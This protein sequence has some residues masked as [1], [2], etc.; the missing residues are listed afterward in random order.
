VSNHCER[1]QRAFLRRLHSRRAWLRPIRATRASTTWEWRQDHVATRIIR[2]PLRTLRAWSDC[3]VATPGLLVNLDI[4]DRN[5]E[6]MEVI[7]RSRGR[8]LSARQDVP[9]DGRGFVADQAWGQRAV[10]G[11]APGGGGIRRRWRFAPLRGQSYRREDKARRALAL[12]RRCDLLLA[13]DS[14]AAAASVVAI[15]AA[16]GERAKMLLAID[17]GL[18]REGVSPQ[19]APAAANAINQLEGVVLLG[20]YTHED[21]LYGAKDAA[22]LA[23]RATAV[24]EF[25]VAVAKSIRR[26]GIELPI[27]SLGASASARAVAFVPGVTQ[28]RP[29]IY[30]FNDVGQIALGNATLATTAIR[31]LATVVSNPDAGRA[32]MDAGSKSMSADLIPA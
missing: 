6:E 29:G 28:I 32:C 9:N 23:S 21:T 8:T 19:D 11:E 12:H 13:T 10:R 31:V 15:F 2:I 16:D 1:R 17:S 7:A 30:A 20:V 4:L 25:I 5:L 26:Q 24:G 18:G 14:V 27:V 3:P 22:A